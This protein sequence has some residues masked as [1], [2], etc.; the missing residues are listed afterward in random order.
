MVCC[1]FLCRSYQGLAVS[2]GIIQIFNILICRTLSKD[3]LVAFLWL[4]VSKREIKR[5]LYA[6]RIILFR[7]IYKLKVTE[8]TS[9]NII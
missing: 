5:I 8:L 1:I 4:Y 9:P 3:E 6:F 7:N 2:E